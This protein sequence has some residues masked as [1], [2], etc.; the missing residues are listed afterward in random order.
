MFGLSRLRDTAYPLPFRRETGIA[1]KLVRRRAKLSAGSVAAR[2]ERGC[3]GKIGATTESLCGE[4]CASPRRPRRTEREWSDERHGSH[5]RRNHCPVSLAVGL[6]NASANL[7]GQRGH[8]DRRCPLRARPDPRRRAR[9]HALSL[10]EGQG[11][12]ECLRR[13]VRSLLAAA[14]YLR[15]AGRGRLLSWRPR[16]HGSS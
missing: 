14:D 6:N 12:Q 11:R 3:H 10:P 4:R 2:R 7:I 9:T 15:Q 13:T 16:L 8:A 5:P 1:E